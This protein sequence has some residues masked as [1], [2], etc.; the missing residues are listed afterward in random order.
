MGV[1]NSPLLPR[2]ILQDA[3]CVT[4]DISLTYIQVN[5]ELTTKNAGIQTTKIDA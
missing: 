4:K 1:I 3:R 5:V 2:G